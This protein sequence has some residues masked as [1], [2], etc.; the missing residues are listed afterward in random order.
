VGAVLGDA[1]HR[2]A[3][4][5]G[6][7]GMPRSLGSVF[8]GAVTLFLGGRRRDDGTV[9]FINT[10][11]IEPIRNGVAVSRDG[12]TLLLSHY[13]GGVYEFS[14]ADGTRWRGVGTAGD[15]P[16]R[17]SHPR[18][19]WSA[20]DGTVF[21]ADR[22]SNTVHVLTPT[23]DVVGVVGA[24]LLRGATGVCAN[25]DVVVASETDAH[26]VTV[27]RRS[28]GA[29]HTRFG[30]LGTGDGQLSGPAG[31]CFMRRDRHVAV[32]DCCNNRVSVFSV[33]GDFIRHIGV[34]VLKLPEG[35]ACSAFDELVVAGGGNR[36]VRLFGDDG[37]LLMSFGDGL[38][39]GVAIHNSTVFATDTSARR[40][41]VLS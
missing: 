40:C 24:G 33:S 5:G 15:A 37:A 10:P 20:P 2:V 6:R 26:R 11:G 13:A 28:D 1:L 16:P 34:G 8:G 36:V 3:V 41:V 29:V 25:A 32:A 38:F 19:V 23:L 30:S 9:S 4:L 39:T 18:Q 17:L 27:F 35:V 12:T 14:V 7:E 21:V 22:L 31:L